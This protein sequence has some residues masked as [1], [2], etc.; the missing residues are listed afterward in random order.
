MTAP[1]CPH[2]SKG[3]AASGTYLLLFLL[4]ASSIGEVYFPDMMKLNG[5]SSR[6]NWLFL[7]HGVGNA[8]VG[9]LPKEESIFSVNWKAASLPSLMDIA[10]YASLF[11]GVALVG[12]QT[13]SILYSSSLLWS[14]LLSRT[15][16]NKKLT[17]EQWLSILLLVIG[18]LIKSLGGAPVAADGVSSTFM[19]GVGLILVGCFTHAL[20]N[21][22]NERLIRQGM[23]TAKTLCCI[24]G[25]YTLLLWFGA[26]SC[27][28]IIPELVGNEF[29]YNSD[30]FQW[31]SLV[32]NDRTG[33]VTL[34]SGIAWAGFV[35]S[36]SLHACCFFMLLGSVGVV[37]SGICK[38]CTVSCYVLLS[39][40]AFCG[41]QSHYCLN[42]KTLLSAAICVSSVLCYSWA[43][44]RANAAKAK[45]DADAIVQSNVKEQPMETVDSVKE[46]AD[47]KI[48]G[49]RMWRNYSAKL[50]TLMGA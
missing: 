6:T 11:G 41:V 3:A 42:K 4:F 23:I 19:V 50:S 24:S 12:A 30:H 8:A 28:F 49:A 36:A 39:G 33:G 20:A 5:M 10:S 46:D 13:K 48:P 18:L 16:L 34:D 31:S 35:L 45:E 14:A 25:V 7:A 22:M 44:L 27:G 26:Y 1:T 37:S 47:A 43:T 9:L 15:I 40:V 38:G 17:L 2:Q 21:V 29:V 32:K